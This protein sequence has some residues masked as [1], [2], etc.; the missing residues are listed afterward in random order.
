MLCLPESETR[1]VNWHA[2]TAA[3]NSLAPFS[4][5]CNM[6]HG[7]KMSL[8]EIAKSGRLEA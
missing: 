8:A 1:H 6:R 2:M 4:T 5:V 7:C 3:P